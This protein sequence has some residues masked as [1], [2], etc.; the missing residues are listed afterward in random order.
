MPPARDVRVLSPVTCGCYL[1]LDV[2]MDFKTGRLFWII[3]VTDASIERMRREVTDR[4]R[5]GMRW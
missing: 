4:R 5:K 3:T 1:I 2:M